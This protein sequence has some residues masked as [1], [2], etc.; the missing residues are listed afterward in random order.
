VH[1]DVL[2][3]GVAPVRVCLA[4]ELALA[5][6]RATVLNELADA[7][8]LPKARGGLLGAEAFRRRGLGNRIDTQNRAGRLEPCLG[9]GSDQHAWIH[10]RGGRSAREPG[11]SHA[12]IWQAYLELLLT[13]HALTLEVDVPRE[14]RPTTF[15]PEDE[16]VAV[17]VETPAGRSTLTSSAAAGAYSAVRKLVGFACPG[18][19]AVT[20]AT[21]PGSSSSARMSCSPPCVSGRSSPAAAQRAT[22]HASRLGSSASS[23]LRLRAVGG[24]VPR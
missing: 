21:S 1:T 11:R 2:V 3:V 5:G 22:G 19:C 10:K 14:H 16:Q 6:V 8:P 7:N 15:R 17:E 13:E 20:S 18:A 9:I 4:A 12:R 24:S 23:S